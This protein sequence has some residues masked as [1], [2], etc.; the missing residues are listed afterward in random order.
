MSLRTAVLQGRRLR[1]FFPP[2]VHVPPHGV[3]FLVRGAAAPIHPPADR[4]RAFGRF[5]RGL[6][7]LG[8]GAF[9]FRS[10]P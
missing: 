8:R 3:L 6:S 7:F 9:S 2:T 4:G 10:T 5:P 1:K